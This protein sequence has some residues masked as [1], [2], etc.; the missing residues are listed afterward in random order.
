MD[1]KEKVIKMA[2]WKT[3]DRA[4]CYNCA[5]FRTDVMLGDRPLGFVGSCKHPRIN[6]F[7]TDADDYCPRHSWAKWTADPDPEG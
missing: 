6:K 2:F 1:N 5:Y 4:Y 3:I 7:K